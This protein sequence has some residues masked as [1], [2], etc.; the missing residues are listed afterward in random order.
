[1]VNNPPKQLKGLIMLTYIL[2]YLFMALC[3]GY[4]SHLEGY[5]F[6]PDWQVPVI[7][8]LIWPAFI[9]IRLL[10]KL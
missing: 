1:M 9:I 4:I 10:R 3:V 8:G 6:K 2:I 5:L 7:I